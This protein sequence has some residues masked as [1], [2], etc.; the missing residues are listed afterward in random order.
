MF[1]F[2]TSPTDA[3]MAANWG[4]FHSS[5]AFTGTLWAPRAAASCTQVDSDKVAWATA[6]SSFISQNDADKFKGADYSIYGASMGVETPLGKNRIIG[7]AFGYDMGK[8]SLLIHNL[9]DTGEMTVEEMQE[10]LDMLRE[11]KDR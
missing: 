9:I 5:Q 3:L 7:V 10:V 6:Y 11:G 2:L 8:A 1:P 4:V